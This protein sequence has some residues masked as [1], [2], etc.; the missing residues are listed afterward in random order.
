MSEDGDNLVTF[1]LG[2][3]EP[4][5]VEIRVADDLILQAFP[6]AFIGNG[7]FTVNLRLIDG[8][9]NPVA[10]RAIGVECSGDGDTAVVSVTSP[11]TLTDNA[12]ASTAQLTA[13]QMDQPEGGAE[14]ECE[15]SLA[16]GEP[17][18]IVLFKGR[19][20]CAGGDG[21]S[22]PAPAGA[23]GTTSTPVVLTVTAGGPT[24]FS[25]L[26]S[27][28]GLAC[29]HPGGAAPATVCAGTFNRGTDVSL[30]LPPPPFNFAVTGSCS[31]A[32]GTNV[33]VIPSL[34]APT[35]CTI[36]SL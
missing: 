5:E 30:V 26:S 9:G 14:W 28:G 10:G 25:L 33:V 12:G 20:S 8:A 32:S 35:A 13:S 1:S 4:A 24:A 19:D 15:F 7:T 29:S 34:S 22:P 21:F 6:T 17:S 23:C 36:N 31:R 2:D 3:A 11:P 27:P 18:A 16:G